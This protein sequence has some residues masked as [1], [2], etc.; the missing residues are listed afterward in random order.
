MKK[1]SAFILLYLAI[2]LLSHG[3]FNP[4]YAQ[5]I[6]P[7]QSTY[8]P[9]Q[10]IVQFEDR[11]APFQLEKE[12]KRLSY[13][14]GLLHTISQ[15]IENIIDKPSPQDNLVYIMKSEKDA[16]V[17]EKTRMFDAGEESQSNT[18]LYTIDCSSS[19]EEAI[20]IFEKVPYIKY[21]QPNYLYAVEETN[22]T[23]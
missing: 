7:I 10:V 8:E 12:I 6:S 15:I 17:V 16:G 22:A 21:A 3:K 19:V 20:N 4:T 18:Y 1:N 23:Y 13:E 5:E 14:K 2:L 9:R 11:Y